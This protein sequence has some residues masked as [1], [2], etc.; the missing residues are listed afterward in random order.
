MAIEKRRGKSKVSNMDQ[1]SCSSKEL[2]QKFREKKK[3]SEGK[4]KVSNNSSSII[5]Q[6]TNNCGPQR[7]KKSSKVVMEKKP[8]KCVQRDGKSDD[9]D[10]KKERVRWILRIVG[11]HHLCVMMVMAVQR[12]TTLYSAVL[13]SAVTIVAIDRDGNQTH[14]EKDR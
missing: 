14:G 9:D 11:T 12:S 8:H 1:R 5:N 13:C 7:F 3:S 4:N 2:L 10:K 6:N